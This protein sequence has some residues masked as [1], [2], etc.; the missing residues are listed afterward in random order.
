VTAGGGLVEIRWLP[1]LGPSCPGAVDLTTTGPLGPVAK[2]M[3]VHEAMTASVVIDLLCPGSS[4]H[5][6]VTQLTDAPASPERW[7]PQR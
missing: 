1:G 5:Q 6:L 7:E 3:T 4:L 2:A